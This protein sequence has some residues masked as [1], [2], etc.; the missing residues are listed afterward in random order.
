MLPFLTSKPVEF[1]DGDPTLPSA[2]TDWQDEVFRT[3]MVSSTSLTINSGTESSS[4]MVDLNY[5]SNKG[6]VINND[7]KKITGRVNSS[8]NFFGGRIKVGENIQVASSSEIPIPMMLE[9]NPY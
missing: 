7:Y 3:G 5:Y 2:D 9:T 6:I 4:L 8:I 1:I